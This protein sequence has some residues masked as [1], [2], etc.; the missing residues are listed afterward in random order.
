MSVRIYKHVG[1][2]PLEAL[3]R[4][5]AEQIA[6]ETDEARRREWV[7]IPMTYAG[8]LDPMAEGELLILIGE[9]CKQKEGYL[10]LD[11]EYEVEILFGVETDTYDVLG[12]AKAGVSVEHKAYVLKQYVGRFMQEYP[13]YSSKTYNGRQLHELARAGELPEEMPAK[14][15]EIYEI[16]LLSASQITGADLRVRI[17]NMIDRVQGD[18][19]QEAIKQRWEEILNESLRG[20]QIFPIIKLRVKCSSG[21]YMRSLAHRIGN[22]AGTCALALTIKRTRIGVFDN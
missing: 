18:F 15:V 12:L 19:R 20:T 6:A 2:T 11:K 9:E 10:G 21:T 7:N 13:P 4:F 14:E 16:E 22:D 3:E 5:R 17:F 8:R 1:E